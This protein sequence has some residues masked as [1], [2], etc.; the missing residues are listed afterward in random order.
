MDRA[1]KFI[2]GSTRL[3]V[4]SLSAFIRCLCA[5]PLLDR[6]VN[7]AAWAKDEKEAG[8]KGVELPQVRELATYMPGWFSALGNAVGTGR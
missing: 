8:M 5:R 1:L 6:N 2:I 7:A 3:K 4:R